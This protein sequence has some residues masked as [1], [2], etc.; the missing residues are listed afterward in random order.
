MVDAVVQAS[1]DLYIAT[2][3]VWNAP[4]DAAVVRARH[5]AHRAARQRWLR[6]LA[7]RTGVAPHHMMLDERPAEDA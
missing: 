1:I 7:A 2:V 6:A 4:A 5:A 3:A